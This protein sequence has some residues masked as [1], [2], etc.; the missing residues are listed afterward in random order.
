MKKIELL[1]PAGGKLAA[2][3]AVQSG[4]DAVYIGGAEFSAR[5]SADNFEIEEMKQILNVIKEYAKN[6]GI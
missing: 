6:G 4:A 5:Q 3:A 1:A 2:I